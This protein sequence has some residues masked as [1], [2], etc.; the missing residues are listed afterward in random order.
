[1]EVDLLD[2]DLAL[3]HI[4]LVSHEHDRDVL[5]DAHQV[6]EPHWHVLVGNATGH[7]KHDDGALALNVVSIAEASEL[8]LARC[9]PHVELEGTT[10]G[11]EFQRVHLLPAGKQRG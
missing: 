5:A 8:L 1:M 10:V 2:L 4:D 7:I 11:V 9:V 6:A 3:L